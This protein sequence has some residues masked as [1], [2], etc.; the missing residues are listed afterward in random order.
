MYN[1]HVSAGM[2]CHTWNKSS[3][4]DPQIGA[5]KSARNGLLVRLF[6][7]LRNTYCEVPQVKKEH[8]KE[9]HSN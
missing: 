2:D 8:I 7:D 1:W 6:E 5:Q 9:V 4:Q 3:I